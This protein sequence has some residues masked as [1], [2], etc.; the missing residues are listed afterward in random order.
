MTGLRQG[1]EAQRTAAP[2][3]SRRCASIRG[4]D[5]TGKASVRAPA[6]RSQGAART[7]PTAPDAALP[8][9][10]GAA[11]DRPGAIDLPSRT[12][13][14]EVKFRQIEQGDRNKV[15]EEKPPTRN[16]KNRNPRRDGGRLSSVTTAI[17]LLKTFTDEDQELGISEIAI[18]L[19]VAKSTVH[20][21]A[22]ALLDEGMLHQNPES[23]RYSL[24]MGLFMLGALVRSRIDVANESKK[25]LTD[26]RNEVQENV[27][28]AVLDR[29]EIVFLH[30]FE[31]PVPVRIRSRTGKRQ[32]AYCTAEGLSLMS[33]L[34]EPR[35][36]EIL[37]MPRAKYTENT[38]IDEEEIRQRIKS[39][40]RKG[41]CFEDEEFEI[42]TRTVAAP[43]FG[44]EGSIIAAIGVAG[45]RSRI[46]KSQSVRLA[47][48]VIATADKISLRMG[49]GHREKIYLT[50][51]LPREDTAPS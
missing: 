5:L 50:S 23:G 11:Q 40:K 18:R 51:G 27:R 31:A 49:F 14:S 44:D 28:L 25:I 24:G 37:A 8:A 42:G 16:E 9:V 22:S 38:V 33:G 32:P 10:A 30:D 15:S 35:L 2:A 3:A 43:V 21:L 4:V 12:L 20:R 39:V 26:F 47:Q 34:R 13:A 45:P 46:R 6:G 19:G 41:F 29:N 48:K 17:H 36:S 1:R 7:A